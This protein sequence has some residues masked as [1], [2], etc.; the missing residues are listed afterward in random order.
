MKRWPIAL[1]LPMLFFCMAAMVYVPHRRLHFGFKPTDI[2]GM[3]AWYDASKITSVIG[4]GIATWEDQGP[5]GYDLVQG[6]AAN[7]PYVTNNAGMIGGYRF[8]YFDGVNDYLIHGASTVYSQPNSFF[9]VYNCYGGATAYWL[10]DGTNI[11]TRNTSWD[12]AGTQIAMNAG[13]SIVSA[14]NS[15]VANQWYYSEDTYNGVSSSI[16]TNEVTYISGNAGAQPLSGLNIGRYYPGLYFFKGGIAEVIIYNSN[17]SAEGRILL[18][19]YFQ[20][21]YGP[22][23]SW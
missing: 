17:V 22:Y 11:S 8:L 2:P 20:N 7:R 12:S 15:K 5:N 13:S 9:L 16:K 4:T 10:Y 23:T 3:I 21:K 6:T 18:R 19:K 1:L 14:L